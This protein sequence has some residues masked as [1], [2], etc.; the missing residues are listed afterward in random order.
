MRYTIKTMQIPDEKELVKQ[1]QKDPKA[2]GILYDFCYEPILRYA[3][4]RTAHLQ[5]SE[6]IAAEVFF[7]AYKKL[8]QF[9]WQD[10]PFSAWLYKIATNE[11]NDYFKNG[12]KAPVPA[13]FIEELEHLAVTKETPEW[14]ALLAEDG[15]RLEE[16]TKRLYKAVQ[17]LPVKYQ[18]VLALRYFEEKSVRETCEILGKKEGTVKSLI[19]RGIDMLE[20][21]M[22][23]KPENT[24]IRTDNSGA[25]SRR[26]P[27]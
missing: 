18:E 3:L 23:P 9:K 25:F 24:V 21:L 13:A 11:I 5:A 26:R 17:A 14:E 27:L 7:K 22:Q 8:W 19:S 6:D 4:K 1:A 12:Q 20:K 16:E 2:F 10:R 15:Q